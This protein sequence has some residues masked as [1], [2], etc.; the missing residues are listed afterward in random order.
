MLDSRISAIFWSFLSL[1][2]LMPAGEVYSSLP[3]RASGPR[4]A[5]K[6]WACTSTT[7]RLSLAGYTAANMRCGGLGRSRMS[8]ICRRVVQLGSRPKT[9]TG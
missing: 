1:H 4:F 3:E 8:M 6:V 7:C 5:L 9:Y 2:T